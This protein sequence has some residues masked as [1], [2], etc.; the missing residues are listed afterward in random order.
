MA[1]SFNNKILQNK[2]MLAKEKANDPFASGPITVTDADSFWILTQIMHD[3]ENPADKIWDLSMSMSIANASPNKVIVKSVVSG[4][5]TTPNKKE[6]GLEF[7]CDCPFKLEYIKDTAFVYSSAQNLSAKPGEKLSDDIMKNGVMLGFHGFLDGDFPGGKNNMITVS[8]RVK[9]IR[10]TGYT[11]KIGENIS[12]EKP[13]ITHFAI[14][15][16][17]GIGDYIDEYGEP[18][19]WYSKINIFIKSDLV[20]IPT[21]SFESPLANE[22]IVINGKPA[23]LFVIYDDNKKEWYEYLTMTRI[24]VDAESTKRFEPINSVAAT[25]SLSLSKKIAIL[26]LVTACTQGY[27]VQHNY[28]TADE[29]HSKINQLTETQKKD[30]A[31]QFLR[32]DKSAKKLSTDIESSAQELIRLKDIMEREFTSKNDS[33]ISEAGRYSDLK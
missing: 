31:M 1:L 14:F 11:K 20:Q 16:C 6:F 2:I 10:E 28:V 15:N 5:N 13:N 8:I 3:S 33:L 29:F 18:S 4:S 32:I 30:M 7:I 25:D 17:Y 19:H 21:R 24:N 22:K 26:G 9:V 27:Y 23:P 12:I